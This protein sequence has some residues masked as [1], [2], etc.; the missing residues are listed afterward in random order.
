MEAAVATLTVARQAGV[1]ASEV[2]ALELEIKRGF[3]FLLR[4]Q[5]TPGPSYLMP[6]PRALIGGFPGSPIDL[7][8]RIDYPQHAGGALLRY[9]EL[10]HR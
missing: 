2:S 4:Y 7:H 6:D 5:Y 9:W 8:V 1:A 3:A 10:E